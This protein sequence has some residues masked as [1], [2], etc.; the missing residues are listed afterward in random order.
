[1]RFAHIDTP[2]GPL[3]VVGEG[4]ALVRLAFARK[5]EPAEADPG[6]QRDDGSLREAMTQI[7]A[8]FEGAL[9]A[10]DLP[11]AP[12]GTDFQRSV[13]SALRAIPY[14]ETRSY[15]EVARA[16]GRPT[17][18]RAVGAANGANPIPL[19]IPC[20]RVLGS[21]G[22]LTGF[23]GGL[24]VKRFLLDHEASVAGRRLF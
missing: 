12:S 21:T 13:W 7:R 23:G 11:V 9:T 6:W 15:A 10:F 8:Y 18:C 3:L 24:P 20:H 5:G 22:T 2:I 19:V 17:A 1:M 4:P 14:G 16:I